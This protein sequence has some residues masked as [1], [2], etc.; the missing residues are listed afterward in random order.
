MPLTET[1]VPRIE[2]MTMGFVIVRRIE[3][4]SD[5]RPEVTASRIDIAMG[6]STSSCIRITG[7]G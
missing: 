2:P 6:V 1:I 3:R 5:D 4:H 7:A